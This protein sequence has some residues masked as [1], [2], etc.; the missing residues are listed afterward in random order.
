MAKRPRRS[1]DYWERH[2]KLWQESGKTQAGYCVSAGLTL[3]TFN[4]WK[5]LLS[6]KSAATPTINKPTT[7]VPVHLVQPEPKDIRSG[8]TPDIRVQLA[9]GKWIVDV[10]YCS[11][12]EHLASV[13]K[14]VAG[15]VQ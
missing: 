5:R 14:V 3:N 2:L 10:P 15:T 8:S 11:D 4:R 13:L 7:L 6:E 1:Q 12:P 9:D